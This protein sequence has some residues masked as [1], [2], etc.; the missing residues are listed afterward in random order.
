MPSYPESLQRGP[1]SLLAPPDVLEAADNGGKG[2]RILQSG[3]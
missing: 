2:G 3:V 1:P